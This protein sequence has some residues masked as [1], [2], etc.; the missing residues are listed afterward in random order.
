MVDEKLA[1][2]FWPNQDPIGRR[3]YRPTDL[4]NIVGITEKTVF[5][6]VVG[7]VKDIKLH[8]L[9]EG[10]QERRRLLLPDGSGRVARHDVRAEDGDRSRRR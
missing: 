10:A 4:N 1:K 5:M 7:V 6:T 2:R 9:A 8:D 3:M